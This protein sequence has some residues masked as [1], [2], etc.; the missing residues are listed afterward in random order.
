MERRVVEYSLQ[1]GA[2][3]MR[4]DIM[5]S[6]MTGG[7]LGGGGHTR[8]S[9]ISSVAA[10][11]TPV[12]SGGS[13]RDDLGRNRCSNRYLNNNLH[14]NY[15][16]DYSIYRNNTWR[17]VF[18]PDFIWAPRYLGGKGYNAGTKDNIKV[19]ITRFQRR[20]AIIKMKRK[21]FIFSDRNMKSSTIIKATA[22]IATHKW[23]RDWEQP[24][25]VISHFC[26]IR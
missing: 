26:E 3:T 14:P 15:K 6:E 5:S 18:T 7:S 1:A 23:K 9:I 2:G 10:R 12:S 11:I 13:V 16:T 19:R 24:F 8:E 25:I 17:D 21:R 4:P 20:V 22:D